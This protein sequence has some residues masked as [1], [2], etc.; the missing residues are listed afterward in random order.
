VTAL[1]SFVGI[2]PLIMVRTPL[3]RVVIAFA[4]NFGELVVY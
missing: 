1:A 4:S 2:S 3:I